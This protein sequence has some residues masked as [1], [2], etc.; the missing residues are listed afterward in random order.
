MSRRP[1]GSGVATI[2]LIAQE[3]GVSAPTVSRVLNGRADVAAET[4]ARVEAL[5][6]KH[7][8]QRRGGAR[9]TPSPMLDLVFHELDSAW[10]V[11]VIKGVTRVAREEGLIVVLSE[12]SGRITPGQSWVDGV[13]ARRPTGVIL[14]LSDLSVTQRAQ[15]MTRNIPFVVVDPAGDPA[16]DVP[17]IGSANWNGGLAATRHPLE[18]GHRRIGV[19]GGPSRLLCSRARLDG[20]RAAMETAGVPIDPALVRSGNFHIEGG[21]DNG[22]ALLRLPDPPTAIFAGS[23]LQAL[24]LYEAARELCVLIPGDLS[25]VG[26]DDLPV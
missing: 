22:M 16:E 13:L 12:S 2:A 3:A 19:I 1:D 9:A 25:V 20:F 10:A 15:L 17:A 18:L 14:V 26:Y 23:D 24:G 4:R 8:Y 11:E 7:G 6:S 21:Y 5:I